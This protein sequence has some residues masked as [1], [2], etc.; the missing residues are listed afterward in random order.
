[1]YS[2]VSGSQEAPEETRILWLSMGHLKPDRHFHGKGISVKGD[3]M[4][5]LVELG[6]SVRET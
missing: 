2:M 3:S 1:M 5:G 4:V 6:S